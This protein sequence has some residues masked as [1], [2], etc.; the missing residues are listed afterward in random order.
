M[1]NN[2]MPVRFYPTNPIDSLEKI[3]TKEDGSPL[4]GEIDIYRKMYVDLDKSKNDWHVW[5]DLKL[6]E[7]SDSHNY[8]KKTSAQIDFLI[9][10]K[11][12]VLVLE[13]KGGAISTKDNQF[14]Y[15]KNFDTSMKQN[16]FK[17]VEGYKYTLKEKILSNL[18]RCFFCEAVAFPH[19][20]YLFE[21]RIFDSNLLWT[22]FN[23]SKFDNSIE[24]FILHVFDYSKEKHRKF[25]RVYY[26]LSVSELNAVK[27]V[28]S[29]IIN[30][31][32][33]LNTI[34]TL[35]WL[36][37]D[38]VEILDGLAKNPRIMIEGPPGSGKTTL[39]KAYIDMQINK[40][41]IFLCW[42]NLLMHYTKSILKNRQTS[43]KIEIT[44]Y[45]QFFQKLNPKIRFQELILLDENSFYNLVK[46]TLEN[47]EE[48]NLLNQYDFIVIDEA[49]DLF[50]R[51]LDLLINKLSGFNSSGLTNGKSL[52]LYDIDQSFTYNGRNVS[53]ISDILKEYYAHFKLSEVRRSIQ[54]PDIRNLSQKILENPE[55]LIEK[56]FNKNYPQV[57]V[58]AHNSLNEIKKYI[59]TSILIPLRNSEA[60]LKG[61]DCIIL[62]EST[63]FKEKYREQEDIYDELNIKDIEELSEENVS[64]SANK[65]RF[66]SILKFKG[67]EKKNVYL[68]I[69]KP[70]ELN[71]Y[72][73]FIGITRAIL[74]LEVH[75]IE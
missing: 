62:I 40:T 43:N 41:G 65:L 64:D 11:Y 46:E 7:H 70:S 19:V 56:M 38:N 69:T 42:N 52:L 31:K 30:D 48:S 54:N 33:Y 68:I 75:I 36:G 21:S 34:N 35:E 63:F 53:E 67:L 50:D 17:Q 73:I 74:N 66:T 72:E 26:D 5:H 23:S 10:C 37:I 71:K 32:S 6:P 59:V 18:T 14:F 12:G 45:F 1:V 24:K 60:S 57:R 13:V 29:P 47:L 2:K 3:I 27:K 22:E 25:F 55:V 58:Q 61:K 49:Q 4:R 20:N 28:L 9:L 51:G 39:A 15:G 8:Y 16:P 44:T